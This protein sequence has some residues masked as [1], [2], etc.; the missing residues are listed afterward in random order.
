MQKSLP[1]NTP[2][3]DQVGQIGGRLW[4]ILYLFE[5]CMYMQVY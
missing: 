4:T 5:I 3:E 2:E 1:E